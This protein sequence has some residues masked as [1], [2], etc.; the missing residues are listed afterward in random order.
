MYKQTSIDYFRNLLF[1]KGINSEDDLFKYLKLSK[2][3]SEVLANYFDLIS[4]LGEQ[5]GF[6]IGQSFIRT[7][8]LN[9]LNDELSEVQGN[10]GG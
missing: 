6:S 9:V 8:V 2:A 10:Q 7:K 5:V 1:E 3:K 4:L